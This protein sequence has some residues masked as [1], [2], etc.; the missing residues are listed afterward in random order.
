MEIFWT[1]EE[2][3][4]SKNAIGPNGYWYLLP[5]SQI[6]DGIKALKVFEKLKEDGREVRLIKN[7]REIVCT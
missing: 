7:I 1:I 4:S 5:D 2:F 3:I 6:N